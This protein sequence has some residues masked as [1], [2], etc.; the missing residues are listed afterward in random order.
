MKTA[1]L[2]GFQAFGNYAVNNTEVLACSL[3]GRTICGHAIHSLVFSADIFPPDGQDYGR[4]IVSTAM[5]LR[6]SVIISFG[7]ASEAR[8]VR[9]ESRATNWVQNPR[10]CQPHENERRIVESLPKEEA[11][12]I[13]LAR[14]DLDRLRQQLG[15]QGI[16]FEPTTSENANNYCCNAL[17][18]RTLLAMQ[19]LWCQIPYIFLHVACTAAAAASIPDFDSKKVII[20]ERQLENVVSI[21][22]DSYR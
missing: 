17:M 12:R 19:Y 2:T 8:G 9:I 18:F 1:L 7:L 3:A 21:L 15:S 20:S 6:A 5:S 4:R 14:W 13:D 22:L 10:Y 11:R 16:P